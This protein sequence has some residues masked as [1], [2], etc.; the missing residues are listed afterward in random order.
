MHF[1]MGHSTTTWKRREGGGSAKSPRL[2]TQGGG[3]SEWPRGQ[4]FE[5]KG[6]EDLMANDYE[7]S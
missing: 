7:K 6:I 4:K 3:G 1:D 5:K 2:S